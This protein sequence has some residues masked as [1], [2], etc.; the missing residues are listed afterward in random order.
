MIEEAKRQGNENAATTYTEVLKI[1]NENGAAE[2]KRADDIFLQ[3]GNIMQRELLEKIPN[4]IEEAK[5]EYR[6]HGSILETEDTYVKEALEKY[7]NDFIKPAED[8]LEQFYAEYGLS[9]NT[10]ASDSVKEAMDAMYTEIKVLSSD[11]TEQMKPLIKDNYENLFISSLEGAISEAMPEIQEVFA[12]Q[13]EAVFISALDLLGQIVNASEE[14]RGPLI[15]MFNNLG[16]G[17][18]GEGFLATIDGMDEETKM[19][20]IEL[21]MQLKYASDEMR[22]ILIN[23][24]NGF[25]IAVSDLGLIRAISSKEDDACT[26][27]EDLTQSS[28]F[29]MMKD[30]AVEIAHKL[31][32]SLGQG[33]IDG[34]GSKIAD[35]AAKAA[36]LVGGTLKTM[37]NTQ[38]SH[39]PSRV[40]RKLGIDFSEGYE[41]GITD[42]E[43]NVWETVKEWMT[44]LRTRFTALAQVPMDIEIAKPVFPPINYPT[45]GISGNTFMVPIKTELELGLEPCM[46]EINRQNALLEEQNKLLKDIREKPVIQDS[47]VFSAY[48]RSQQNYF[49]RTGRVGII[50][51]D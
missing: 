42:N 7:V 26:A 9:M 50:G 36:V 43:E 47:D 34:I 18:I 21:L 19:R 29:G 31:G 22:P 51:I 41:L 40:T 16:I 25:G 4:I 44:S 30:N 13:G 17:V 24:L 12:S 1:Q 28:V 38:E 11:G 15:E 6:E 35:A 14:A 45:V 46:K 27:G 5:R 3:Y 49:A 23:E 20:V 48:R 32:A 33:Y 10:W 37:Q 8:E 2:L 39:S